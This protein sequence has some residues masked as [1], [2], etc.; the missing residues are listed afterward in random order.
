MCHVKFSYVCLKF[1]S[2]III[3]LLFFFQISLLPI[4]NKYILKMLNVYGFYLFSF[5]SSHAFLVSND[6]HISPAV[7]LEAT[8]IFPHKGFCWPKFIFFGAFI[9][10]RNLSRH[11]CVLYSHNHDT[12]SRGNIVNTL[13]TNEH[14]SLEK[15]TSHISFEMVTKGLCVRGEQTA[16]YWPSVPLS[17]AA[18][19]SSSAG[20]LDRGS[21]G[22][23]ALC[24]VLVL[25]TKSNLQLLQLTPN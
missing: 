10:I 19:L 13:M 1:N 18:L 23:I 21:W 15:Y 3:L 24:W 16:T 6:C 11:A 14:T 8:W 7:K 4:Q 2:N 12:Y 22:P 9:N 5:L 20:L 17:L 25:T